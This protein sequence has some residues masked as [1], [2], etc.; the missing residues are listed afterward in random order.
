MSS[1]TVAEK[2]HWKDRIGKRIDKR[3]ESLLAESPVFLERVKERAR[4]RAIQTLGLADLQAEVDALEA[5]KEALEERQ[6][7]LYNQMLAKVR[8]VPVEEVTE[9][10]RHYSQ[11]NDVHQAI[12]KRR[13]VHE[14]QFLAEDDLG[15]QI[16]KLRQEKD[17]LLDTVWIATSPSDI[18]TLW[19]KVADVLGDEPTAL[20]KEALTIGVANASST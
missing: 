14:E 16:L 18:R 19:Q 20:Q 8:G 11:P 10:S 7:S 1:L 15:M 13:V 17:N 5:Q 2:Q 4:L 6:Q 12:E 3:I 9:A